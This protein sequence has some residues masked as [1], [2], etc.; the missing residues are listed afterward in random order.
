MKDMYKNVI[1]L[2]VIA[3][4]KL[5]KYLSAVE[6]IN[7]IFLPSKTLYSD[8]NELQLHILVWKTLA[9]DVEQKG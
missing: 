9:N 5:L 6:W 3:T 8:E 2:F 1:A 4:W 7:V